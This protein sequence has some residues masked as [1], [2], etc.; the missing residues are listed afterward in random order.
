MYDLDKTQEWL[1]RTQA[2][3]RV[4]AM[5]G[6]LQE[7]RR[8]YQQAAVGV[9]ILLL[10]LVFIIQS[11][12][13]RPRVASPPPAP[14]SL[15]T[16]SLAPIQSQEMLRGMTPSSLT[17]AA[18]PDSSGADNSFYMPPIP[19]R[20]GKPLPP[21]TPLLPPGHVSPPA[22]VWLDGPQ[23]PRAAAPVASFSL[24]NSLPSRYTI[25]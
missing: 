23:S 16:A 20:D 19:M 12:R 8:P 14:P 22:P 7:D 3:N 2:L 1:N 17:R 21:D 5:R 9:A 6:G 10:F 25:P 13:F 15:P 11:P 24:P 18:S 4:P